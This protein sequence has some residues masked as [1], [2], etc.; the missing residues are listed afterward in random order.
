MR[1]FFK[2]KSVKLTGST[3][4]VLLLI[5]GAWGSFY[6]SKGQV[7]H[8]FVQ[9]RSSKSGA[10]FENIKGFLVWSDTGEQITNDEANYASFTALS[11][12]KAQAIGDSLKTADSSSSLY[13]KR[14]GRRFGIFPDY[15]VAMRPMSL[16]L[17]TNVAKMDLL[18]NQKKVATTDSDNYSITLKRLPVADYE[19]TL[20]GTHDGRKIKLSKSYKGKS[21]TIDLSVTFKTFTVTS[22]L[23]DGEL[24]FGEN[25]IGTLAE[26]TYQVENYPITSAAKAVVKKNFSDG[27]LESQKKAV[28]EIADGSS[29]ALDA[30]N[31]LDQATAGQLVVSAFDQ[32]VVY[33]TSGRDASMV[34]SLFEAGAS[35]AFYKGLKESVKAKLTTD[36]RKASQ[37]TIPNIVLTSLNQ[38]GK[39]S[40]QLGFDA[41]YNFYYDKS[42]DTKKNTYGNIVQNLSGSFTVKRSDTS[43]RITNSGGNLTVNSEDNQIK[44]DETKEKELTSFPDQVIGSWKLTLD[45][46]TVTMTFAKDGTVTKKVDFKDDKQEDKT[47]TAK[48]TKLTQKADNLYLYAY[49]DSSDVSTFI[50]DGGIGGAGVKYAYGLKIDGDKIKPVVWQANITDDFDYTKPLE[51]KS[52]TKE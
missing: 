41:T 23:T 21:S 39:D 17:K 34:S 18:L 36:S 2:K 16:T 26:G 14:V 3:L 33:V 47:T 24:Y 31:L 10:A 29:V 43:Y 49:E 13:I 22:N 20:E 27:V 4:L 52:L 37:L 11:K 46:R 35:N 19:A 6:F 42:T 12:S 25:R 51:G 40:Y 38:V 44:A 15:K 7:I 32:L 48:V 8:R 50:P 1:R 45:D 30:E 5:L 28:T 9:A